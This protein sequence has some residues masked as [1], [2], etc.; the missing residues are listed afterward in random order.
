MNESFK[1]GKKE[2]K[3]LKI[4][5]SLLS[6]IAFVMGIFIINSIFNYIGYDVHIELGI[7]LLGMGMGAF[8]TTYWLKKEAGK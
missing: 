1:D 8:W 2:V 3:A 5:K 4:S 7:F 6:T